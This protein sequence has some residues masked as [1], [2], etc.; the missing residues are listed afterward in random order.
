MCNYIIN[1]QL[2]LIIMKLL[3]QATIKYA[4]Q[5]TRYGLSTID[6]IAA[7]TEDIFNKILTVNSVVNNPLVVSTAG[8]IAYAANLIVPT[9]IAGTVSSA[10]APVISGAVTLIE[11]AATLPIIS[12]AA[13]LIGGAATLVVATKFCSMGTRIAAYAANTAVDIIEN[14]LLTE[15][16]RENQPNQKSINN[17]DG[18]TLTHYSEAAE[19]MGKTLDYGHFITT[20]TSNTLEYLAPSLNIINE[21]LNTTANTFDAT[22]KIGALKHVDKTK[23]ITDA[24]TKIISTAKRQFE[25]PP[26]IQPRSIRQCQPPLNRDNEEKKPNNTNNKL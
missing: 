1:F 11:G 7:K 13:T 22:K 4:I 2:N 18:Y 23:K 5:K 10:A 12:S 8:V 26:I 24:A 21:S 17:K 14:N 6:N 16:Y 3:K 20:V 19:V 9:V 15:H 25:K